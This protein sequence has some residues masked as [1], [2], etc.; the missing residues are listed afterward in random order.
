MNKSMKKTITV[1]IP[2]HNEEKNIGKLLESIFAQKQEG[3]I[4]EKV[5]VACD[6]CTDNTDGI[7]HYFMEKYPAVQLV[8]DGDRIGKSGR[9]NNF[10]R[11]NRSD[12]LVILDADTILRSSDTLRFI[13]EAFGDPSIGLVAGADMPYPPETLFESI[14]ITAVDLWRSIRLNIDHGDTVHNSHGCA[15]AFS[16]DFAEKLTIPKGIN[17][18][19]HYAYFRSKELGFSFRYATK[20]VVNYREPSNPCDFI[21]QRSRFYVINGHMIEIFGSWVK[22]YYKS[23]PLSE[24]LPAILSM[25]LHRPILLP[26]ALM[27]EFFMRLHIKT[28][29]QYISGSMWDTVQS[30]KK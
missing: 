9:S 6:G 13:T 1:G 12:I 17:G 24:K 14:V 29:K 26:L 8:N 22:P 30:T 21:I 19:D 2:A 5:I 18:D 25:F 3:Y 20:A 16:K 4:L 7:A 15:L 27:L 11:M 23:V 28:R 10:F